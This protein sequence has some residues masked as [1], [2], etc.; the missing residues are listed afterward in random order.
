MLFRGDSFD[1]DLR[2]D[3]I[4]TRNGTTVY[5]G[6]AVANREAVEPPGLVG[7]RPSFEISGSSITLYPSPGWTAELPVYRFS[8]APPREPLTAENVKKYMEA[9]PKRAVRSVSVT[10]GETL[11][12]VLDVGD[13]F[14]LEKPI[15]CGISYRLVRNDA[16][17]LAA[18]TLHGPIELETGFAI[19]QEYK[20]GP[21]EPLPN[22]LVDLGGGR[23]PVGG[24]GTPKIYVIAQIK[25]QRFELLDGQ[26]AVWDSCCIFIARSNTGFQLD[27]GG[28]S[29]VAV[30]AAGRLNEQM[31]EEIVSRAAHQMLQ[32][33]WRVL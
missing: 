21:A 13:V 30:F 32:P 7:P 9:P 3:A 12:S 11:G 16:L 10:I 22:Q 14:R 27:F 23:L 18:G 6:A 26:A 17:V 19:S 28:P 31:T 29:S 8:D 4:E 24:K 2:V 1:Y 25:E 15:S 33:T 20:L 5:I